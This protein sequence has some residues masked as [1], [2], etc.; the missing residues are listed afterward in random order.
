[1]EKLKNVKIYVGLFYLVLLSFFLIFFFSKFDLKEVTSYNFIQSNRDYFFKLKESNLI[2]ISF[3]F[4]LLTIFWVLLL[5]FGSPVALLGGFIFG[6]WL[7]TFLVAIGLTFGAT[8]FYMIANFFFKNLIREKFLSKYQSLESKFKKNEFMFFILYRFIGGIPFQ[9]ANLLPVL[10]NVSIKNYL[11]GTFLGILPALF[12]I[13]SLGS[14]IE[15]IIN[16]NE[17]A[18]SMLD[19]LSSSEIYI[20]ILGFVFLLII[21]LF[22]K[23][24]IDVNNY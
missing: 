17:L 4:L 23:K 3:I 8:I 20:P 7:G 6:K 11:I 22:I 24:K 5:G 10:F 19:M 1:M 13:V 15:N 9:I 12:V 21:V 14:G 2:I 16:Q 18:P